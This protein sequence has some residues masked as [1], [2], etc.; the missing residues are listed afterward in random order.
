[1]ADQEPNKIKAQIK[2]CELDVSYFSSDPKENDYVTCTFN[3]NNNIYHGILNNYHEWTCYMSYNNCSKKMSKKQLAQQVT[4]G[5]TMIARVLQV[6]SD[7]KICDVGIIDIGEELALPKSENSSAN[8]Q[9]ELMKIFNMNN[10][11]E[12]I[13]RTI[14]VINNFNFKHV[15]TTLIYHVDIEKQSTSS[16]PL[17][18]LGKYFFDNIDKLEDW[19]NDSGVDSDETIQTQKLFISIMDAHTKRQKDLICKIKTLFKI[20]S[21]SGIKS[22]C[23]IFKL[24]LESLGKT[25]PCEYSLTYKSAPF[26]EFETSST[27][28]SKET[29]E[30]FIKIIKGFK[31]DNLFIEVDYIGKTV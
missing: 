15:W 3:E 23:E 8:I 17:E 6:D 27:D 5:K 11:F 28:S 19:I 4:L 14:C 2:T 16:D 18:T 21:I 22:S 1:M 20:V 26:W 25:D 10:I 30:T 12:S 7:Q 29:H 13:I 24:G 31:N 9:I